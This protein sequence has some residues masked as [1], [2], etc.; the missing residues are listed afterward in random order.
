M[1]QTKKDYLFPLFQPFRV[2]IVLETVW[3]VKL[4]YLGERGGIMEW[5][6]VELEELSMGWSNYWIE[7]ALSN[8]FFPSF[9]VP[10]FVGIWY[11]TFL[12]LMKL[13]RRKC[14]PSCASHQRVSCSLRPLLFWCSCQNFDFVREINGNSVFFTS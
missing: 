8:C 6:E 11:P 7:F 1:W 10:K 3:K 4:L 2:P 14:I 12:S 5:L 13:R 9:L